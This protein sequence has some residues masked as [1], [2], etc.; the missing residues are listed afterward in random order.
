MCIRDR[1]TTSFAIPNGS[2][3]S[4]Q[5][6][7]LDKLSEQ[8]Q[9][10]FEQYKVEHA[11]PEKNIVIRAGDGTGKTYTMISSIGFICY[12]QNVPLQKMA[13]RIA[14]SYTHLDVYK[15]QDESLLQRFRWGA[16]F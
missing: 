5:K 15:R 14:V 1:N 9:F 8:S 2:Y 16:A 6:R 10:N 11:T 3:S 12:T 4:A 13:D 7:I